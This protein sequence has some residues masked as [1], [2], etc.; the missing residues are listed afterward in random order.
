MKRKYEMRTEYKHVRGID[1]LN[2][3]AADAWLF[4]AVVNGLPAEPLF[5]VTKRVKR[6][7]YV[8]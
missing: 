6:A 8:R 7:V 3:A 5:L 1:E 4:V 2:E